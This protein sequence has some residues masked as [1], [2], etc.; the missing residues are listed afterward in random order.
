MTSTSVK[1]A[2]TH[3]VLLVLRERGLVGEGGSG[4]GMRP[5]VKGPE[6]PSPD[7]V[8]AV[9]LRKQVSQFQY[10]PQGHRVGS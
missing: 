7:Q 3:Q 10:L 8:T 6:I 4:L 9:H 1:A 5:R 2:L